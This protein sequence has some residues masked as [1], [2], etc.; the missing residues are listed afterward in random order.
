MKICKFIFLIVLAFSE[1]S[2]GQN[3]KYLIV[4]KDKVGTPFTITQP[5][6]FLSQR[7]INRRTK[8][9][10]RITE[11]DLPVNPAYITQLKQTGAKVW[12]SSRWYNAVLVEATAAQLIAIKALAI[13]KSVEFGKQLSNVRLAVKET[14]ANKFGTETLDYGASL[15]QIQMLGVDKMHDLGYHG[16]GMLI[17]ILDA[18]F[19]NSNTNTAMLPIFAEN[20]VLATY[21][22]VKNEQAVYEDDSHG[23]N[24]FSIMA[25]YKTGGLIGPAYKSSFLLYR[26][27]DA[28]TETKVEEANWLIAAER[29]DSAGVDIIS[30]SLGY[31]EFDNPADD[32]TYANMNGKTTLISRAATWAARVGM[33]VVAANGNEGNSAWKFL[34]APADADSVL[35]VGAVNSVKVPAVFTSFGPSADGR[36][37]P[38]VSAQGV[39][40]ILSSPSSAIV[41]GNGTSY[42]TP[43]MAG[44]AAG[45]W[46]AYPHLT[47]QQVIQCL[48]KAGHLY[49]TPTA[50][51]GYGVPTFEKAA[52]IAQSDY[53]ITSLCCAAYDVVLLYPNPVADGESLNLYF[54]LFKT[55]Q[56]IDIQIIG[57]NGQLVWQG[58]INP[59]SQNYS[60]SLPSGIAPGTYLLNISATTFKQSLK[61]VKR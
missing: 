1:Y 54:Q 48:R 36:I 19:Q 34:G 5:Q 24:C 43:L 46:Q 23:N 16:E 51:L 30:T 59:S 58:N 52:A 39:T 18:G 17:G 38:D 27:E 8:Q 4:L 21:D 3:A 53:P 45:L 37:K 12:Y 56:P 40:T 15:S 28:P 33:L 55:I 9:G 32:Y 13:Y 26:T 42:S 2:L 29:A 41:G 61:V 22:F 47:A 57:M 44:L 11:R 35:A 6:Q 7:S 10:I 25:G 31:T 14:I 50:Q 60:F 49:Q 20:R